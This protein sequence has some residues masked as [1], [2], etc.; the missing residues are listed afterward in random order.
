MKMTNEQFQDKD[1]EKYI[2]HE[3]KLRLHNELFKLN[4]DKFVQL[5]QSIHDLR[6]SV[7]NYILG[8]YGIVGAASLSVLI[9]LFWNR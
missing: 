8:I 9:N 6:N 3:V 4:N 1:M 2:E 7:I 5:Q